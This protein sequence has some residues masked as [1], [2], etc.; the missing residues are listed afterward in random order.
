MVYIV[1]I[2]YTYVII[3]LSLI[4]FVELKEGGIVS[5]WRDLNELVIGWEEVC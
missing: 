1:F 5:G 3:N 2:V 4:A